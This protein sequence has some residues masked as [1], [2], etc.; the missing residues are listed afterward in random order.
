MS[1]YTD[2]QYLKSQQYHDD[3]NLKARTYLHE[4]FSSNGY[5]WFR[6][7]FDKLEGL[8]A[9]AKILDIGCGPAYLWQQSFER[10]PAGWDVVLADLS[11]GML[12]AAQENLAA[13][14]HDFTYREID[15]QAIP[16]DDM[17]FDAVVANHMLYHV[18]DRPKALAEI[19][20]VLK[21]DGFLLAAT[22]GD[23]HLAEI[24]GWLKMISPDADFTPYGNPFTLDN[25]AKQ[26]EPFF[27]IIE[28][29]RYK[30][31]LHI[32]EIDPLIAYL[33]STIKI[34]EIDPEKLANLRLLFETI[35]AEDGEIFVGNDFGAFTV[36]NKRSSHGLDK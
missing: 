27:S 31:N 10:I 6:W 11:T 24:N 28:I 23:K 22:N 36:K 18:P 12:A 33:N 14:Q 5:G 30:N 3:S 2:Q 17:H 19:R 16:F 4:N 7:I 15:A 25:G 1:K 34:D 35:L 13:V 26:L 9:D 21:K 20:R 29:H 8:P 32:T